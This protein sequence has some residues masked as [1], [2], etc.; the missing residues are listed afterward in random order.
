M[1]VGKGQEKAFCLRFRSYVLQLAL[2][3]WSKR[4]FEYGL[5]ELLERLA[6]V[7]VIVVMLLSLL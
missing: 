4:G 2:Q 3:L 6:E 7:A 5:G 1:V